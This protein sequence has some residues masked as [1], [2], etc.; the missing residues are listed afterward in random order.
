MSIDQGMKTKYK[1]AKI[2]KY[3]ETE[4]SLFNIFEED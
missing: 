3:D 2:K 4:Y 1:Q